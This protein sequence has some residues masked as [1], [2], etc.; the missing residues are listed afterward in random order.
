MMTFFRT[1]YMQGFNPFEK[2]LE[3]VQGKIASGK[4]S[5]KL[6]QEEKLAA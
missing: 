6:I 2:M 5:N 1:I 4:T 3:T